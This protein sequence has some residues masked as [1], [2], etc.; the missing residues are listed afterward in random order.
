MDIC[1]VCLDPVRPR[2]QGLQCDGCH[3]WCHRTCN[4]GISQNQYRAAVQSGEGIDWSCDTCV[5]PIRLPEPQPHSSL[6]E[7]QQQAEM[8]SIYDPPPLG[9]PQPHS[10]LS[11]TQQEEMSSIYDPPPLGEPLFHS[12]FSESQQSSVYEPPSLGE[13][14]ILETRLGSANNRRTFQLPLYLLIDLLHREARVTALQIRYESDKKLKKVQKKK[15]RDLQARIFT[16]C[17][18]YDKNHETAR[19]LLRD[20]FHLNTPM[21]RSQPPRGIRQEANHRPLAGILQPSVGI[22]TCSEDNEDEDEEDVEMTENLENDAIA[23]LKHYQPLQQQDK[24]SEVSLADFTHDHTMASASFATAAHMASTPFCYGSGPMSLPSIPWSTIRPTNENPELNEL[25]S[26]EGEYSSSTR[27]DVVQ[28]GGS[29]MSTPSKVLSPIFEGSHEDSKS[30]NSSHSSNGSTRRVSCSASASQHNG[31]ELSKIQEETSTC[32]AENHAPQIQP[33]LSTYEGFIASSRDVPR[34]A[35]NS[36]VNLG[37]DDTYHVKKLIGS[38]AFAKVY[39]ANKRGDCDEDDF[40]TDDESAVVLKVQKISIKWEFYV[41]RQLQRRIQERGCSK[42]LLAMF[43]NPVAAYMYDNSSVLVDTYKPLGTFL[44]MVNKIQGEEEDY[45][46]RRDI[47]LRYRP[48]K[49]LR[50]PAHLWY[51]SRRR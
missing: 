12:S 24:T 39:L 28:A 7:S 20:C 10:S 31:L 1:L 14:S 29:F 32:Q 45:G 43:M 23:P 37:D 9:E 41:S 25:A 16:L 47:L 51:H 6:S 35:A 42:E 13:S 18:E 4:T 8:S 5:E 19:Q 30:T 34:I 44:D 36:S 3:R 21:G 40:E 50:N 33:P 22:P 38:G 11:E 15:Y 17:E 48:V 46:G 27:T 26:D 49:N 2:Q